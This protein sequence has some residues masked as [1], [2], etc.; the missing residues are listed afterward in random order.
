MIERFLKYINLNS[1]DD[2]ITIFDV[3]SRDCMQSIEF[4]NKFPN[5]KIYDF[6][7]N[8]NTIPLCRKNIKN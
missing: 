8:P 3:G 4:Y 2:Y 1:Y 7:C 5:A 6:E